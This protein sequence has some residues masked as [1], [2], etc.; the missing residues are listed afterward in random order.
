MCNNNNITIINSYLFLNWLCG[1]EMLGIASNIRD[2]TLIIATDEES[3]KLSRELGFLVVRGDW[4]NF[5]IDKSAAKSFALGPH[6]W[7][8]ALQ[9]V[10]SY[11]VISLGYNI[12]QQD[13]DVVWLKDVRNFFDN[14]YL[15]I[16]MACDGRLDRIGP[17]NTGF[18]RMRSNCKTIIYMESLLYY[19]GL[20][21][22]GRSDQRV[23]NMMLM[24]Y[25]FRQMLFEMLPPDQFVGGHQWGNGRKKGDQVSDHIWFL[26][27]SWTSSHNEKVTKFRMLETWFLNETCP[28]YEGHEDFTPKHEEPPYYI[29]PK[30][31]DWVFPDP[32]EKKWW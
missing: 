24:E 2:S 14:S 31:R 4:L 15:D 30:F 6:R 11:D 17:G 21:L 29:L 26:H 20:V 7:T 23:W 22:R 18:I 28:Y 16:E 9:I 5:K 12:I 19:I 8:V 27:S 13:I 25:D 3:E 1:L 10:Y 32:N